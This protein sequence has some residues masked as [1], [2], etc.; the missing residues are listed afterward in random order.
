M[1][2]ADKLYT[3]LLFLLLGSIV[4]YAKCRNKKNI[5]NPD[6]SVYGDVLCIDFQAYHKCENLRV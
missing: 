1:F 3:F 4:C 2:R 6:K 5:T